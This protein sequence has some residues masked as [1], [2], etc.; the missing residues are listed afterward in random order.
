MS[1]TNI[2]SQELENIRKGLS[3]LSAAQQ[4]SFILKDVVEEMLPLIQEARGKRV[5]WESITQ[6]INTSLAEGLQVSAYTVR[7]YYYELLR[8]PKESGAKQS[9]I[10]QKTSDEDI[11]GPGVVVPIGQAKA[12]QSGVEPKPRV[13]RKSTVKK[14]SRFTKD[15]RPKRS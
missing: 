6:R 14:S 9:T 4:Q 11:V 2:S 1:C 5:G 8:T 7:Q 12:A 13:E 10:T 15:V 3:D